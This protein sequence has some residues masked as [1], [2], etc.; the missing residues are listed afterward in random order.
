MN[1][2]RILWLGFFGVFLMN[3][4]QAQTYWQQA[5]N[6]EMEID[7]DVTKH[8]FS[9]KQKLTYQNNSPDTLTKVFYHLYFNAFQP[10]S[11]MDVRSRTITDP[12]P[13][14]GNRIY[15]LKEDEIGYQKIQSLTQ[16]GKKVTYKTVGTILEVTLDKPILPRQKTVFKMEFEAQV[17]LQIRRSGR[18]NKEGISYSMTQWYPKLAEYDIE[19]WHANP[20]IGREFHG[21]WGDF[22]V[23]IT[24]DKNYVIGGTGYL[25]NPNEIGHGYTKKTVEPK[26]KRLTWHFVAPKVHDF[27]WGADPDY[28]HDMVKTKE[29]IELHFFYQKDVADNWKKLPDVMIE[30]FAIMNQKFGKYPYKQYSFIQGGDGGMEY[31]MATL[32]TG[33]RNFQSLV[34]VAVHESIHSWFQGLLATN[35]AKYSWMDEGFTTYAQDLILDMLFDT[36]LPNP[37]YQNY[38]SYQVMI[39]RNIEEPQTTHADHYERNTAYGISSYSKGA[40]FLHQLSYIIGQENLEKGML[41]YF[42]EWKFKHPTARDFKR[43]MEKTSGLELDW[44]FE[45][46]VE[47]TN[48]IDYGIKTVTETDGK[49]TILLERI[50]RT[51]MPLDI[52]VTQKDGSKKLYYIP[53]RIMRGEKPE[54]NKIKRVTLTDWPWTFP[55]YELKLD[56]SLKNIQSIQINPSERMADINPKNDRFPSLDTQFRFVETEE[57]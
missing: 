47:T 13:R 44:Y 20:Y 25:Q 6:Y 3:T 52:L 1:K 19:G 22:D 24:I 50:G 36:K 56:E 14:V 8:Q 9:G 39:E 42:E 43:V 32:I 23:K 35:E 7:F 53:L 54:E 55:E 28:Q 57:K 16:D 17:P 11:M 34:S 4:A 12:D 31:P 29:G 41:R 46:W 37:Q 30:C 48:T 27:A 5:V 15:K 51:P 10:N 40:V 49:V 18:D 38:R 33:G 45:H 26:T 21:V 2:L